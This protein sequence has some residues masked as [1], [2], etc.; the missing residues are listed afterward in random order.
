[1]HLYKAHVQQA[2]LKHANSRRGDENLGLSNMQCKRVKQNYKR[3]KKSKAEQDTK[4]TDRNAY[5]DGTCYCKINGDGIP[6][7]EK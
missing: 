4:T 7:L 6:S 3:R 1:M 5:I 2:S